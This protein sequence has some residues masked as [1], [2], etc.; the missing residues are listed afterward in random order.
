MIGD[1]QNCYEVYEV[2]QLE[3]G[4]YHRYF[5]G[6]IGNVLSEHSHVPAGTIWIE[7]TTHNTPSFEEQLK[8]MSRSVTPEQLNYW[9]KIVLRG[10]RRK[11][12]KPTERSAVA[13]ETDR[14]NPSVSSVVHRVTDPRLIF[15]IDRK[16]L[17]KLQEEYEAKFESWTVGQ[18][19]STKHLSGERSCELK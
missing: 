10:A 4:M 17:I 7:K 2:V 3:D 13:G 11:K 8:R 16:T 18:R 15:G 5:D 19:T 6:R 12:K 1:C 9:K 14:T